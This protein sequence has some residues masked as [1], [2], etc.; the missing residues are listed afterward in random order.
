MQQPQE[1]DLKYTLIQEITLE[2]LFKNY[3]LLKTT[4]PNH[5]S[6]E[7]EITQKTIS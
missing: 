4:F 3:S 2:L 5:K 6:D 7:P 1:K